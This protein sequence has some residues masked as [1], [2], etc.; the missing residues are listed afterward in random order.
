MKYASIIGGDF[1]SCDEED[2]R[3][4][5]EIG[6]KLA[7]EGATIVCGG[8]GGVMEAVC[9]GAKSEGGTTIGILTSTD[10]SEGN[11]YLDH[12]IVTGLD[13]LRNSLVVQNGDIVIAIDG[14]YGTLS[15]IAL[16]HQYGKKILG[17]GTWDIDTVESCEDVN[18]VME[19]F[20]NYINE[21]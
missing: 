9:R 19:K 17:L 7:K 18:E 5:E 16:A 13:V 20:K 15:E 1:G 8:R 6:K 4:A 2:Y 3:N 21:K 10:R 14:R 11:D 12:A